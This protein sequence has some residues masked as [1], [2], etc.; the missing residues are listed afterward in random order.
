MHSSVVLDA[1][2][3]NDTMVKC[4]CIFLSISQLHSDTFH[5]FLMLFSSL[6]VSLIHHLT[7]KQ[8][9]QRPEAKDVSNMYKSNNL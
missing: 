7:D 4:F 5:I 6:L 3:P 2:E 1:M 9:V 8:Q